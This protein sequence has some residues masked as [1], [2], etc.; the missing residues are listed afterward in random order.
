MGPLT[1]RMLLCCCCC[2]RA[3]IE[4]K[5]ATPADSVGRKEEE[6]DSWMDSPHKDVEKGKAKKGKAKSGKKKNSSKGH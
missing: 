4:S 2:C 5:G 1:H 6:D 3:G